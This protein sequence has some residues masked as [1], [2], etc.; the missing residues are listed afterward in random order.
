[1]PVSAT[2]ER[3]LLN[4]YHLTTLDPTEWPHEA[5]EGS[6][7]EDDDDDDAPNNDERTPNA[8][9]NRSNTTTTKASRIQKINRHASLRSSVSGGQA[10][11]QAS[12][13]KDEPDALG[14]APS[15]A[16]ELRKRG[17]P[18]EEDLSLRNRFMLSSTTFNPQLYLSQ[19]HQ[20]ASTAD[21]LRG[22]EFLSKSIEQKS[23]SLKVLVESN[24]ERFVRAKAT[25]D[26][27]YTEM[28]TQGVEESASS[29]NPAGSGLLAHSRH[30]S[31]G[32]SHFRNQ[33]GTFG[34][35]GKAAQP[36]KKK[37]ALTKE[38]E[39][40]V[41]GIKTPLQEV[42]IKAEEVWG[43]ALGGREKEETLKAVMSALEQ[44]KDIFR[45]SGNLY[46][47]IKKNDFDGVINA[48]KQA[49]QHVERA[50]R[51]ADLA[52]ENNIRL[53]EA[54]AQQIIVTARMWHDATVQTEEFKNDIWKR[55]KT[56]HGRSSAASV[57]GADKEQH[58]ELIGLLL[59]LGVDENPIWEW[60]NSR[61]LY[62]KEKIARSFERSR[63]DIEIQ[64]RKLTHITKV[65][66]HALARHL[67][68]ASSLPGTLVLNRK[69]NHT[70]DMDSVAVIQF[71]EK[72]YSALT[73]L[74]SSSTGILGEVL[75]WWE[76]AQSFITNQAQKSFPVGVFAAGLEHLQLDPDHVRNIRSGA[77][78]LLQLIRESVHTFF[79]DPP[80]DDLSELYNAVPQ[81]PVSPG[82]RSP[83]AEL[84]REFSFDMSGVTPPPAIRDG[85]S[86]KF[87]FWAPGS[88]SLSSSHY[89]ARLLALVGSAAG[90]MAALDMIKHTPPQAKP[91]VV[92]MGVES[93]KSLVTMVRERCIAALCA[94]WLADAARCRVL[95]TWHRSPERRDLTLMPFAFEAWME[96]VLSNVQ[97]LAYVA[98][99]RPASEVVVS[100]PAKL[101]GIVRSTFVTGLYKGLSGMVENA[102]GV[103][104]GK[105]GSLEV[106][107]GQSDDD[108][109]VIRR[110]GSSAALR[111]LLG[112]GGDEEEI[113]TTGMMMEA[114]D[115][116]DK[117]SFAVSL[118]SRLRS[119][120]Y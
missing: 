51:I 21:L 70:R 26:S 17:L 8:K 92:T 79:A 90:E 13:Q 9:R 99:A 108:N 52:R 48:Y 84:R 80:V 105:N 119:T 20:T 16:A 10:G 77:V 59:Q 11:G 89:L 117:V 14:M 27:V 106:A 22:L 30:A 98:D 2:Q 1:M 62:L 28:R 107:N 100:P 93:L 54:D 3:I 58:M 40:G 43:P 24:F 34:A 111:G 116:E 46:D 41:A 53:G 94:A 81:T 7:E 87:A 109:A 120:S 97:K 42:A 101:L 18:V 110:V 112:A 73:A 44:H 118:I 23:A 83:A 102:E 69:D 56:S 91:G 12:V 85:T 67:R 103:K 82:A 36:G 29:P 71:W 4:Q 86:E 78:R 31:R 72:V 60:I 47:S 25:I 88:N 104:P 39:Y 33:S 50:K 57:D 61:Y 32:Q 6:D 65:D 113:T 76:V 45:V 37:T 35:Q 96:R 55:L 115:G 68:S 38:S 74:L 66:D 15:V 75:E 95:E 19:V 5:D 114:V 49:K 63:I 64:R